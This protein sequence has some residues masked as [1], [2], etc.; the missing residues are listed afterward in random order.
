MVNPIRKAGNATMKGKLAILGYSLLA[1]SLIACAPTRSKGSRDLALIR[2][3]EKGQTKEVYRLIE[4]GADVNAQ[5]S[6]GWTPYLAA[7]SMGHLDAMRVLRAFGAKTAAPEMDP[8]N[9]AHR[10]LTNN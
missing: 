4:A 8:Q 9:V 6:E 5:D 2:A 1:L 10:Y 3:A 7:S